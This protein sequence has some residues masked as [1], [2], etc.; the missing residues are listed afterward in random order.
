MVPK[1]N[2]QAMRART[3]ATRTTKTATQNDQRIFKY[4]LCMGTVHHQN[5]FYDSMGGAPTGV[6]MP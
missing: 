4:I 3:T 1:S 6:Y 2:H 5:S